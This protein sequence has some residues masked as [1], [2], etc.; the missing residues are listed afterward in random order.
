V[1]EAFPGD[2]VDLDAIVPSGVRSNEACM[3]RE[4]TSKERVVG[5]VAQDRDQ[6]DVAHVLFEVSRRERAREVDADQLW[7]GR[8][9]DRISRGGND[10]ELG[11]IEHG[12]RAN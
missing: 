10:R 11:R 5:N 12:H 2:V 6:I 8:L 9:H 1:R 4:E 3:H 7:S